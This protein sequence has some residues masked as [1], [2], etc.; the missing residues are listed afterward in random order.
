MHI[1]ILSL[2]KKRESL[3]T[4]PCFVETEAFITFTLSSPFSGSL[5]HCGTT[6]HSYPACP[7]T[8]LVDLLSCP[9]VTSHWPQELTMI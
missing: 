7:S 5:P 6:G 3:M 8:M 1:Q 2:F 4:V 9:K